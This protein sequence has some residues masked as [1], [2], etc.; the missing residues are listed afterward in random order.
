MV[1]MAKKLLA[2]GINKQVVVQTTGLSESEV[3]SILL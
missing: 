1:E 2:A 3:D